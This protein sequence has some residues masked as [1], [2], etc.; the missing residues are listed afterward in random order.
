MG[1]RST[2]DIE[3]MQCAPLMSMMWETGL[4]LT[5]TIIHCAPVMSM[6][7]ETGLPLTVTI[8][9][10]APLMSMMWGLMSSDEVVLSI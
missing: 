2:I 7:W 8:I 10:C 5:V 1:N 9:Q 6:M 3:I 4:P